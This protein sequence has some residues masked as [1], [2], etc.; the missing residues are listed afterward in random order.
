MRCWVAPALPR[1]FLCF[2]FYSRVFDPE[3]CEGPDPETRTGSDDILAVYKLSLRTTKQSKMTL[4]M[5]IPQDRYMTTSSSGCA[6]SSVWAAPLRAANSWYDRSNTGPG[7]GTVM[8]IEVTA[9]ALSY[10][11]WIR[12]RSS[13]LNRPR[14]ISRKM[15]R[16]LHVCVIIVMPFWLSVARMAKSSIKKNMLAP[17]KTTP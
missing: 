17:K 1:C 5:K 11:T 3:G 2:F 16:V 6:S 4:Q 10:L 12:P 13:A 7:G 14:K 9:M 15:G 8:G